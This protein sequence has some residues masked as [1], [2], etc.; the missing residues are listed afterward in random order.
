MTTGKPADALPR[1]RRA[2]RG[3]PGLRTSYRRDH[4]IFDTTTKRAW[5]GLL[6][7]ALALA[8]FLVST[9]WVLLLSLVFSAS[10]GAMGLNLISGYAGQIS[11]GHAFFLGLGAYTGILVASP[12]GARLLGFGYDNVLV[13]LPLAGLVPALVGAVVAPLATR[14]R[15]LYLA[16]V[17]LGLV[18]LGE[19]LFREAVPVTGGVGT[20][21]PGPRPT[22]FGF[23]FSS[24]G[25]ILGVMVGRQQ[26]MY[27]L[28]LVV[29]VLLGTA[30]KNLVRS[31]VGRSFAAVRDR[32][33]AAAIMGVNLNRTK[34][35]AF[36]ISSFYA[37]VAGALTASITG[38]VEPS[39]YNL[40]LS[41]LYIAMVI[42]GGAATIVGSI[43]GAAFITL[44]PRLVQE[45]PEYLPFISTRA[46]GSFPT[47]FQL[48]RIL[49]GLFIIL[50]VVFEPRGLYGIWIRVR[51][52]FKAWPFSY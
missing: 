7:G 46:T 1:P 21:R 20:G 35:L 8:P 52:Y 49:Y 13:L 16:V 10:I 17:T 47:V 22:L 19:H 3:R 27:L 48:E 24:G 25:E 37:G 12:S 2:V 4:A 32:D 38:F 50:F 5:F 44:M 43:L 18:L 39:G 26:R 15:G 6:L 9:E 30:A 23:E 51:N 14:L 36:A 34:V 11:L 41:I 40:L 42:I 28:A 29:L 45:L 33:I 31:D